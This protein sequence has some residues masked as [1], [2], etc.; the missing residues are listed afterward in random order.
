VTLAA[1][2]V[3]YLVEVK[4]GMLIEQ[5]TDVGGIRQRKDAV[6]AIEGRLAGDTVFLVEGKRAVG[7]GLAE[8]EN[9][10][11]CV[12]CHVLFMEQNRDTVLEGLGNLSWHMAVKFIDPNYGN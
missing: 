9:L 10:A 7:C 6:V 12:D 1:K 5:G 8:A 2:I 4:S 11:D 3:L